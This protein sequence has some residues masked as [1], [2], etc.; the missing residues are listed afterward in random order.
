[1]QL[2]LAESLN[3]HVKA[4]VFLKYGGSMYC[5]VA[6]GLIVIRSLVSLKLKHTVAIST[7]GT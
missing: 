2:I 7:L 4:L 5:V 3:A 1:M 6:R